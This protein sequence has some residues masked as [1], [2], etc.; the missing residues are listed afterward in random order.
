MPRWAY[1][2]TVHNLATSLA[3]FERIIECDSGG[4]CLVHEVSQE[5]LDVIK[6]VLDEEGEKGWELVQCNYHG[7][8][9]LCLWK[10]EEE[11]A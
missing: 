7:G 4:Q 1:K 3:E 8:D 2:A 11:E 9:L 5:G 6:K 10:K